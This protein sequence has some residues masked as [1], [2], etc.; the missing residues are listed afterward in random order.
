VDPGTVD[1][2][3]FPKQI[4]D[5]VQTLSHHHLN[6]FDNV[7]SISEDVSDFLCRAITG[8]GFSKRALYKTDTDFVYKFKRGVGVNGINLVTTR[9]DFL[10]RSLVIKLKRIPKDKRR[11]EEDIEKEFEELRPFVLGHIFDI[12]VKVLKYKEEHKG[13]MILKE[14][15]RMADFAEWCEIIAR[16]LGYPNNEF[17]Q[18][19]EENILNQND[20]VIE[21]SPV[22]ESILLFV[23][24][25]DKDYWQGTPTELY[26]K[27]TDIVA[28]IKPE[29]K[30][31]N[32]WP[33]ASN[34][35][36]AR[37]NEVEPNLKEKG[38]EAITGARDGDGNRI[39]KINNLRKKK[40]KEI[41]HTDKISD[42]D[43]LF[44]P[45]IHRLGNSDIW[46]CERCYKSNDI[47]Y[48]KQHICS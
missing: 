17:I 35:L 48:M 9:Q 26:K 32:L 11:K 42:T 10:D 43:I 27:L 38:I 34:K 30:N 37:I 29:L 28:Q 3:S 18:V 39:I 20:E 33:K 31:S 45:H 14:L 2:F 41:S 25:M 46:K 44:N 15:P 24:E 8:A 4:N 36:T 5:L 7:S 21:S 1:T 6:L 47:H 13:Q 16:C 23:G 19:Y 40:N 22:A 12:L